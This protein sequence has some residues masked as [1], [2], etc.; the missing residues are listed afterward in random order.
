MH[1]R[2]WHDGAAL[3]LTSSDTSLIMAHGHPDAP[4]AA[5]PLDPL[6][7]STA[8]AERKVDPIGFLLLPQFPIYALIL[9]LESLRIAN[10]NAGRRLFSAHL[11]SVDGAPVAAGNGMTMAA[12]R[13]IAEVPFLPTVIVCAGNEPVQHITKGLLNWLRR[14]ER[15]GA[16]LGA[17]DTGS[18]A[19]AA[20]GLLDGYQA[21][22][23]WER[24]RCS[25]SIIPRSRSASSSTSSIAPGRP[26]PAASPPST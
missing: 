15:H 14:L 17:L 11:F 8:D 26:A 16:L 23:H 25:A 19:L 9:A 5:M 1:G 22:L 18:F 10:Q 20:A 21:T 13:A 6:Q 3:E 7:P 4:V 12:E 2:S 24:S